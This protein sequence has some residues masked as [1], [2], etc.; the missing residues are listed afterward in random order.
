MITFKELCEKL[1][2]TEETILVEILEL[3]SE[4][5]VDRFSDI[6][7]DKYDYLIR[8]FEDEY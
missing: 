6:I 8:E 1:S 5:I 4:D 7:D 2:E 3:N